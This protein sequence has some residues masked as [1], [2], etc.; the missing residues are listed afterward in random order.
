MA[1]DFF[2]PSIGGVEEHV[3]NLSQMLLALG[4]K[5]QLNNQKQVKIRK[6]ISNFDVLF[7]VV[8]VTHAYGDCSGIRYAT[9]GLKVYYL[10][11]K[12]CYNQCIL[13]TG[14]CNVPL[15]R[16][17]LLR[18][19][20]DVVHAHSAF[21]ALAIET[22]LVGSLLGLKV[23]NSIPRILII[24]FPFLSRLYLLITVCL[25]LRICP[26]PSPTNSWRST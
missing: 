15:L 25:A 6:I 3:Y 4:H 22:I 16:T 11:I 7:Q 20:I 17:I 13:P 5:V 14:V 8:V 12:V 21:S 26:L 2:Y 1:S 10:P 9:H 23:S 24:I 19:R 18:E